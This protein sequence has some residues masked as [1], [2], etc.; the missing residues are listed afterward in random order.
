[1]HDYII[2]DLLYC[3]CVFVWWLLVFFGG[4]GGEKEW[5]GRKC[6]LWDASCVTI[7]SSPG[8]LRGVSWFG[9]DVSGL[10]IGLIFKSQAVQEG[11]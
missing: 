11:A 4:G 7:R 3:D 5:C 8:L 2:E 6:G 9:S 10:P 1:M